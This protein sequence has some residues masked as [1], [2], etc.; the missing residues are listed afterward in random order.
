MYGWYILIYALCVDD[1]ILYHM[2]ISSTH[3][4][5]EYHPAFKRRFLSIVG[6][7]MEL[8]TILIGKIIFLENQ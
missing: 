2:M 6:T 1:I 7:W 3:N 8:K 5:K 4:A